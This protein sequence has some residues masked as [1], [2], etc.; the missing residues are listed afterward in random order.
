MT[1]DVIV[2]CILFATI[3]ASSA[4]LPLVTRIPSAVRPAPC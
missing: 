4:G 3:K 2:C 1:R